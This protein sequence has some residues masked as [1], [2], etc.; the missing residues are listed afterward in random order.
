[1]TG[2]VPAEPG[3]LIAN[4]R[5]ADIYAYGDGRVLR[6]RRRGPIPRHEPAVMRAVRSAGYP[7]PE[8]FAV[9]GSD[10]VLERVVGT[11][12]LKD[13]ERHPWRARRFGAMLAD[14]HVQLASIPADP[15][16]VAAGE[17]EVGYGE[18]EVYVHSDL[19]PGNVILTRDGPVVIDWEGARA[20]PRDAEV[21]STW[22]VL[23]VGEPDDL[24]RLLRPIVGLIRSQL[25]R[26]FLAGVPSPSRETV[27]AICDSR[28]T[29]HNMRPTELDRIRAF[30][31][32]HG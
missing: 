1:V 10:M 31:A 22:L 15:K 11:D 20:G 14:L 25:L 2:E 3:P 17:V 12:M 23:R 4:G 29:D 30:R 5:S 27:R 16:L 7:A 21:A 6:R 28:L 9:D 8:V 13:L 26:S 32:E 19:H 18:P 24:P